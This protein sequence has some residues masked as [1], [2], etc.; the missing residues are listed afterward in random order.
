VQ[1]GRTGAAME[2]LVF[3]ATQ[4]AR[5]E[6]S[7]SRSAASAVNG[8]PTSTRTAIAGRLSPSST[9]TWNA[10]CGWSPF[11]GQP[12]NRLEPENPSWL[13][14]AGVLAF[15]GLIFTVAAL[16]LPPREHAGAR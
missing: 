15:G 3:D 8:M 10:A 14:A 1:E 7:V 4:P 6:A 9:S 2:L 13:I 11:M 5:P 16:V 12:R